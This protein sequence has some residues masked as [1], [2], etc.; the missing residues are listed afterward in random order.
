MASSKKDKKS[1]AVCKNLNVVKKNKVSTTIKKKDIQKTID[2]KNMEAHKI[3]DFIKKLHATI[4]IEEKKL[5]EFEG[6]VIALYEI[7]TGEKVEE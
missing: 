4:K 7:M 6:A 2:K 1:Q 5:S 3:R